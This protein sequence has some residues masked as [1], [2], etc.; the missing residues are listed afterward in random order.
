MKSTLRALLSNMTL[1][2]LTGAMFLV[3]GCPAEETS[4]TTDADCAEGQICDGETNECKD[5]EPAPE[6]CKADSECTEA[7]QRCL[8]S[9]D[10][11]VDACRA[12]A[13]CTEAADGVAFCEA[14]IEN[15]NAT[16]H[17]A[18]CDA[19]TKMCVETEIRVNRF[20]QVEDVSTGAAACMPMDGDGGTDLFELRVLNADGDVIGYG[21]TVLFEI[22]A[23][24]TLGSDANAIFD[25]KP[26]DASFYAENTGT[27]PTRPIVDKNKAL[28]MGCG[29]NLFA[30]FLGNDGNPVLLDVT[31][32]IVVGEI[33]PYC[34][35]DLSPTDPAA[36]FG[37][38]RFK[39]WVCETGA[40]ANTVTAVECETLLSS[41]DGDQ[42]YKIYDLADALG[43]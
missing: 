26:R 21:K 11:G 39:V 10:G 22:G 29:G 23:M 20:I 19:A 41:P 36:T 24:P 18:S 38:D 16:T 6:G 37:A 43:K 28:S 9:A 25:G 8:P 3:T 7:G 5:K 17:T 31:H 13:D 40:T 15:F 35:N 4:C 27:C 42:G 34:N 2:G 1:L 33:G 12:P 32:S 30:E 14:A